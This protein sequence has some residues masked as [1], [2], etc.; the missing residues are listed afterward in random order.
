MSVINCQVH[1][2]VHL[3]LGLLS[4]CHMQ[5]YAAFEICQLLPIEDEEPLPPL[6]IDPASLEQQALLHRV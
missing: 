3:D 4:R 6:C 5:T 1:L 2:G